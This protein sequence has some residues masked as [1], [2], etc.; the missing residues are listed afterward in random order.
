MNYISSIVNPAPGKFMVAKS[1]VEDFN[2]GTILTVNPGE[3][4]I[5]VNQG[6]IVQI[7]NNG[8]YELTTNNFPFLNGFRRFLANGEL[9][10]RCSIFYIAETQS[11][12]VL[13]GFPLQ[14][15]DPVQ[16]IFTKLFVRGAYTVRVNDSGKLLLTLLGMNIN[17]M[18]A[19]DVKAF[20]GNRFQQHITNLVANYINSSNREVIELCTDNFKVTEEVAPKLS[21]I[22]ESSGL[23]ITNFSISAMQIDENDPNRRILE[24]AYA[25]RREMEIMGEQYSTIKETEM[26]TNASQTPFASYPGPPSVQIMNG[27]PVTDNRRVEEG[28][29][30]P[31][32]AHPSVNTDG[33]TQ[34]LQENDT[35]YLQNMKQLKAMWDSGLITEAEY[36]ETKKQILNKMI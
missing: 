22:V 20:F 2:N 14:I 6:E 4:A 17:F 29:P 21:E 9:T 3:R 15:R 33:P 30:Y 25:K 26:R 31:H 16:Q 10:Y 24:A 32:P 23:G 11:S 1:P 5:F 19:Q 36:E 8:R 34:S 28:Y 27:F 7:F 13:W 35:D 18:A 12:E